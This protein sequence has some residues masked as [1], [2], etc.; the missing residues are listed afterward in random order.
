MSAASPSCTKTDEADPREPGL[1][2]SYSMGRPDNQVPNRYTFTL[3]FDHDMHS[4]DAIPKRREFVIDMI[5]RF[6]VK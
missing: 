3:L 1:S 4:P 2:G 6:V 5:M